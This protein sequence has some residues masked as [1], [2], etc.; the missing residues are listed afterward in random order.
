[1]E[2]R[3]EFIINATYIAVICA[4]V[5]I[6]INYLLGILLP[7]ILGFLFAYLAIRI[8]H[9]FY[10]EDKKAN[11]LL[12][13]TAIYI[14]VTL[15]IILLI[16]LGINKIGDFI[17]TLPNFYNN[18][19]D[20][21]INSMESSII[22]FSASLP[23]NLSNFLSTIA[24][25]V[26]EEAKSLIASLTSGL[27]NLTTSFIKFAPEALI[28]IIVTIVTSFYVVSDYEG[29]SR[30]FTTSMPEKV[31]SVFYDIK[32]FCENT[33]FKIIGSYILIMAVTFAE[34]F[35]G[36]SI[37]GINNA[38]MWALFICFLDILP[39][40]GVGTALNPW[41]ISCMIIGDYL[42][43][44]EIFA[45]YLIITVVRNIIE[46]RLVGTNLGLHP[47][48]TLIAMII[49]LKLFGLFGMFAL[50][51]TLSFLLLRDKK[52]NTVPEK[53]P[54]PEPKKKTRKK[55]SAGS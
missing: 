48:A 18:T 40:L 36:F 7:F 52:K 6:G 51:L 30:W 33:L 54:E 8:S 27:V 46:P 32:D 39:I 3:K 29:I 43:G 12:T 4:L 37:I 14:V 19:L 50:P 20:P 28:S 41:A 10:N 47:L 1:M 25:G 26:F 24:D 22:G 9:R 38:G 21:Y 5:Y 15:L 53:E 45:L 17:K 34:L 23:A 16:I 55:K 42:L 49:G 2:K 35:L 13:L 44:A 11:R 31:L